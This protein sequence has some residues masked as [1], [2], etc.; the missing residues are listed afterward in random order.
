[1]VQAAFALGVLIELLDGPAA[2]G[3][4]DQAVE[5][6]VRWQGTETLGVN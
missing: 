2:V 3:H 4:L 6:R 5:W 1:M